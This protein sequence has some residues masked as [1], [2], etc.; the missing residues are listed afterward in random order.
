[1]QI[2]DRMRFAGQDP[3]EASRIVLDGIESHHGDGG[4][5]VMSPH[6]EAVVAF[7]SEMMN[8]AF[9]DDDQAIPFPLEDGLE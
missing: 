6:G 1:M 8:F 4:V 7:N 5:I 9:A 2:A 3:A